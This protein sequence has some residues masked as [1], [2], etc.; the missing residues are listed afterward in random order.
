MHPALLDPRGDAWRIS[1]QLG[2]R[3]A[4]DVL[5]HEMVH[6]TLFA[7]GVEN[8]DKNPHHNTAQWCAEIMR[9]TP[10]LGLPVIKAAPVKPRRVDGKVVRRELD[11]QLSRADIAHWPH[12][13][14]PVGYYNSTDTR[15]H[16][17]I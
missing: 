5:L 10:Q 2:M 17:P 14:R 16:V 4:E 12:S 13:L 15:I 3:Y 7:A 11:G 9:I 6:V 1:D 8:D